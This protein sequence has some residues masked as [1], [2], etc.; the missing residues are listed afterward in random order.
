MPANVIR[1]LNTE[2]NR[3]VATPEVR[4]RLAG[5]GAEPEFW[6]PEQFHSFI[7]TEFVKWMKLVNP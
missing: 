5:Q 2:V 3:I 6:T 1:Q 4:G 7:V